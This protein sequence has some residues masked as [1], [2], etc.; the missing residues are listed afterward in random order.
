MVVA[1][2][3]VEIMQFQ[4]NRYPLL[5]VDCITELTPGKSAV[6]IKNFSYNEWFFPA[7]YEDE[8]VVP[9]FVT[10]ESMAQTF[11]MTILTLPGLAGEKSNLI[12]YESVSFFKKIVPS[13]GIRNE[14]ELL[15]WSRGIG[16]GKVNSFL[17]STSEPVATC[18]IKVAISSILSSYSPGTKGK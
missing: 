1:L 15:S 13:D 16:S 14:A 12:S 10:L 11:I 5:F 3:A 8:P 2:N 6:A 7:H 18:E 9:G 4:R 17:A